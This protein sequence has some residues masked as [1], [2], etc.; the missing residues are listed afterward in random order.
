[1]GLFGGK[2][3]ENLNIPPLKNPQKYIERRLFICAGN[4][5]FFEAQNGQ[6][7]PNQKVAIHK[8]GRKLYS[9]PFL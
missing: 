1:M 7:G 9:E 8:N 3:W 4:Y 6:N 5:G 2:N